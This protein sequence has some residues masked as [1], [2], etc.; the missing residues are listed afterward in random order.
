M[1][2]RSAVPIIAGISDSDRDSARSP[3]DRNDSHAA[4]IG[5][6]RSRSNRSDAPR[7]AGAGISAYMGLVRGPGRIAFARVAG[8][9]AHATGG[10]R[11]HSIS[12]PRR[13]AS[14]DSRAWRGAREGRSRHP[15]IASRRALGLRADRGDLPV[16]AG[17]GVADE[18]R[19]RAGTHDDRV[20]ANRRIVLGPGRGAAGMPIDAKFAEA[21]T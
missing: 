17:G 8:S 1:E 18:Y 6:L 3:G 4:L 7:A 12:R 2:H 11:L 15:T 13:A 10:R 20:R 9:W 19:A 5:A 21:G 14:P 16:V